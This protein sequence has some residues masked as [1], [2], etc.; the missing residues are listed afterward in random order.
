MNFNGGVR[1]GSKRNRRNE[2]N[3]EHTLRCGSP[4]IQAVEEFKG[5]IPAEVPQQPA[6]DIPGL[7]SSQRESQ[8]RDA[9]DRYSV[10]SQ[11]ARTDG[12][13]FTPA[14]W[15]AEL[16]LQDIPWSQL[17]WVC[18]LGRPLDFVPMSHIQRIRLA[19]IHCLQA[20]IVT[21]NE[22]YLWKR[23]CLLPTILLFIDIGKC[24]R[25]DLDAKVKLILGNC[26]PFKGGDFPGRME[27]K[28][29]AKDNRGQLAGAAPTSDQ[30]I[31]SIEDMDKRRMAY[32]K[33]LMTKGEVS[34][35]FR[36]IVLDAKVL[37][38]SLDGLHFLL[39]SK[40]P[41][42]NPGEIPWN[43]DEEYVGAEDPIQISFEGVIKLIRSAPMG[44]SCGVDN[45]PIDI[46]KQL[47]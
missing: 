39:Q 18:S 46:L 42:A 41:A 43:W 27:R 11:G 36:A 1:P 17:A 23:V 31:G 25:A 15:G 44:A 22:Y 37:P 35:A 34:K 8:V 19:F 20:V 45:F 33:K 9:L 10:F 30:V 24:R 28:V 13:D 4:E 16:P 7:R 32:F 29:Q 40:N 26:L 38:Y 3:A 12:P 5:E 21:P 47:T 14:D 6:F 2:V